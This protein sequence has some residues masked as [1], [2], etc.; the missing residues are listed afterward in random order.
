[1]IIF[2]LCFSKFI[3][4]KCTFSSVK[5][6]FVGVKL[7]MKIKKISCEAGCS[8]YSGLVCDLE[9]EDPDKV[10]ATD[11]LGTLT[12]AALPKKSLS[13]KNAAAFKKKK[14]A[15]APAADTVSGIRAS[16][17]ALQFA[18][19][20]VAL[21]QHAR[22]VDEEILAKKA[23]R[24]ARMLFPSALQTTPARQRE[25]TRIYRDTILEEKRKALDLEE[26]QQLG[27]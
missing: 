24:Q 21:L 9:A 1:M 2:K 25:F 10:T 3:G 23:H 12:D 5:L 7:I 8:C 22:Q 6:K 26:Q 19:S 16:R 11:A 15:L 27:V 20:A 18:M 14:R 17:S 13:P 4:K